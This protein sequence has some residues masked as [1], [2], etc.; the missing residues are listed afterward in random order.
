MHVY[1]KGKGENTIVLLTGLGTPVSALDFDPLLNEMTKDN[2][3]VVV[4]TFGYGW[5]EITN[6]E[7]KK[8]TRE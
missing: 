7:R 6:K 4:E 8:N 1:T 2:R 5:S 3:I